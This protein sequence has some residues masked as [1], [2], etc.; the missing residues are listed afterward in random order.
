[1]AADMAEAMMART[2]SKAFSWTLPCA[3]ASISM[4]K[5][6][7]QG[8]MVVVI[9]ARVVPAVSSAAACRSNRRLVM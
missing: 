7:A 3:A 1:M 6:S 2:G 9:P 8:R 5:A 4:G